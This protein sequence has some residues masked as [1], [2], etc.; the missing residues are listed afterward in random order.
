MRASRWWW[1]RRKTPPELAGIGLGKWDVEL[2]CVVCK[3]LKG[4]RMRFALFTLQIRKTWPLVAGIRHVAN[5]DK[6]FSR[7]QY[8]EVQSKLG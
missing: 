1:W 3:G 6:I 2:G 5:V 8:A 4:K 7:A